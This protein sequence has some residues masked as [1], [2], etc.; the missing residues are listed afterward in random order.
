[1]A[2][3]SVRLA[4][5]GWSST[6][7]VYVSVTAVALSLPRAFSHLPSGTRIVS[8]LCAAAGDKSHNVPLANVTS[9]TDTSTL[10]A[11]RPAT[12][13]SNV[14]LVADGILSAA[15]I[16]TS[17]PIVM[18][19]SAVVKTSDVATMV[20]DIEISCATFVAGSCRVTL[21]CSRVAE[22]LAM[23]LYSSST[24]VPSNTL[25]M[26][27]SADTF[28]STVNVRGSDVFWKVG[29]VHVASGAFANVTK[30]CSVATTT[31]SNLGSSV[32][33]SVTSW[34]VAVDVF[35]WLTVKLNDSWL[36]EDR[37]PGSTGAIAKSST[38]TTVT[39]EACDVTFS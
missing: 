21:T 10:P 38:G 7:T 18:S 28:T 3:I 24:D 29:N 35:L 11:E 30:G 33:F 19:L 6:R 37:G 8:I 27:A 2:G 22:V 16:I 1:M 4:L 36:P 5:A 26:S 23:V 25:P 39:T 34:A 17:S 32:T 12:V 15:A 9:V 31:A 14:I 13:T 20:A